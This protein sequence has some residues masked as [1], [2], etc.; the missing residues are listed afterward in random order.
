MKMESMSKNIVAIITELQKVQVLM[1]LTL[2]DVND[3]YQM[4][5]S[6]IQINEA[7][8]PKNPNARIL[9]YPF[10]PEATIDD[11][12]FIRAYYNNGDF[13]D[14]EVIAESNIFIDI[15]VAKSLWLIHDSNLNESR[16]R[17]YEM[18][19]HIINKVGKR[20]LG[21]TI[22]LKINGYQHM[23]VNTKFECIRLYCEY[24]SVESN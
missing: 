1:R 22:R 7:S 17:P 10:D 15:I 20:S 14:S 13:D 16:I 6:Q 23:S 8:D 4:A 3:P 21:S 5:V 19:G 11:G 12:S 9:P 2:N 18:M 24:Y